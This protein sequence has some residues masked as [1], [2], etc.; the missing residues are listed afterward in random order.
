MIAARRPCLYCLL[1]AF[2]LVASLD[3]IPDPPAIGPHGVDAKAFALDSHAASI[4]D[5]QAEPHGA[6]PILIPLVDPGRLIRP[7]FTLLPEVLLS[8][9]SDSSPPRRPA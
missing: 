2:L 5:R 4:V 8:R 9:A 7:H 3:T 1:C 6:R